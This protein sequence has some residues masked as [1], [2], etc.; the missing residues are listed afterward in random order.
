[1]TASAAPVASPLIDAFGR[2]IT[3]VRI[4]VTDRCNLRCRYCMPKAG[5]EWMERGTILSFD[6]IERFVR[7]AAARGVRKIRLTGGEPM[8]RRG[9]TDLVRR[10]AAIPGIQ[11]VAMTTNATMLARSAVELK[12]AGLTRLNISLDSLRRDRFREITKAD[13]FDDVWAGIQAALAAGFAPLKLN[14][15]V[16]RGFNDDELADF[17]RLTL[18]HAV[19]VRFIEYMPIGADGTDWSRDRVVPAAEIRERLMAEVGL[20][21]EGSPADREAGGL[22]AATLD[23]DA[24]PERLWRVPG[25]GRVGFISAVSDEFC[26]RCNRVRL[27]SDGMLR[28]CLMRDG[29]VDFRAAF[30]NA[31]DDA[32][33]SAL[34]DSAMGRKPEKHLINSDE[35]VASGYYT[36]NRLGG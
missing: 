15:V 25:G 29:E 18:T 20:E 9:L 27:T 8:V 14:V 5:P 17:A 11:T 36:M 31:A 33:I 4:S 22:P 3:Y 1:M 32:E 13:M 23:G 26:A 16:I 34:L 10:I 24:G 6:E 19:H 7:V 30:R 28:G 35:F 2:H 21:P 12:A